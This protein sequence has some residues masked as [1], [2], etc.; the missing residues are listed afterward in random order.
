MKT[1]SVQYL[2]NSR[3]VYFYD[4]NS[5]DPRRKLEHLRQCVGE[6]SDDFV[7]SIADNGIITPV[8]YR[9][10]FM[11][12]EFH[13]GFLYAPNECTREIANGLH[14]IAVAHWLRVERVPFTIHRH[15]SEN[16]KIVNSEGRFWLC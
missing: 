14:R 7:C 1:I 9:P 10:V 6:C 8:C 5:N 16:S 2:I 15:G 12:V 11:G 4:V 13:S 3:K